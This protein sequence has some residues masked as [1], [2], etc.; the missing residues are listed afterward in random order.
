MS[1]KFDLHDQAFL[2][3]KQISRRGLLRLFGAVP[4][5]AIKD[6]QQN[7]V[8]RTCPRPPGAVKES[9]FMASCN[10]CALCVSICPEQVIEIS[11]GL[12]QLNLN[13]GSCSQCNKCS[14]VCPSNA[15]SESNKDI[16]LRP[17]FSSSCQNKLFGDCTLCNAPCPK[18]AITIIPKQL[19]QI[20]STKCDGCGLCQQACPF[21]VLSLELILT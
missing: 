2:A 14:E 5:Q 13:Y 19:P 7:L 21:S 4:K 17:V 11:D 1:D 10:G 6:S 15:L 20:D 18:E 8:K 9:V 16:G 3:H 12:A